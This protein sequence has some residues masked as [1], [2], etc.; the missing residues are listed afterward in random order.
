MNVNIQTFNPNKE[1]CR[2]YRKIWSRRF[3]LIEYTEDLLHANC[4]HQLVNIVI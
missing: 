3:F 4:L 1:K 2:Y